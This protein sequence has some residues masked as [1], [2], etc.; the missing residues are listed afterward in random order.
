MGTFKKSQFHKQNDADKEL[1]IMSESDY[2]SAE[3]FNVT[4]EKEN[5][6]QCTNFKLRPKKK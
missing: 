6:I 1:D 5:D 3:F 4:S 2:D